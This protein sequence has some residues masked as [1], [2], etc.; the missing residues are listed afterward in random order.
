MKPYEI[1]LNPKLDLSFERVV[2][3][4]RALVWKAWTDPEHLKKW[5]CPRPWMTTHVEI[6]LRPGGKF[7]STMEGPNGEKHDNTG[8]YLEVYPNERLTWTASLETGFRPVVRTLNE[9]GDCTDISFTA[10]VMMEDA[11]GGGTKYTAVAMHPDEASKKTH[12]DMGFEHG[13]GAAL[14]Q[15]VDEIKA[16]SIK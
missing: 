5:F 10:F 13:W 12:E 4:P 6:D 2:D 3:V 9:N 11:P 8:C 15:L 7:R 14:Q 1:T 16:G